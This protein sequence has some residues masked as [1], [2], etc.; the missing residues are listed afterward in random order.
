M[1]HPSN[2]NDIVVDIE[3]VA[4]T[5]SVLI[6]YDNP[7]NW[8][9]VDWYGDLTMASVQESCLVTAQYFLTRKCTR[10]LNDNTNV[11][12]VTPDVGMW[13]SNQYVPHMQLA[14]VEYMAWVL[15]SNFNTQCITDIALHNLSSPVVALFNDIASAY[16]WLCAVRFKAPTLA[17]PPAKGVYRNQEELRNHVTALSTLYMH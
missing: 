15:S 7:N 9:Y 17:A 13:L 3:L 11:T 16:S 2:L 10:I 6:Y 12:G 14:G 1:L 5:S 8:L 4:E